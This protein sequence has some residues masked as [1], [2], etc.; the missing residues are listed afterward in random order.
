MRF[1]ICHSGEDRFDT[2]SSILTDILLIGVDG[3]YAGVELGKSTDS[4]I[5]Q[6]LIA[7]TLIGPLV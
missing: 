6:T 5:P 3:G 4:A 2:F 1:S 7:E